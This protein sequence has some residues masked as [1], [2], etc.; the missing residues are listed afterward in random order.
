MKASKSSKNLPSE[1]AF[2]ISRTNVSAAA[3]AAAFLFFI[4]ARAQEVTEIYFNAITSSTESTYL[5]EPSNWYLDSSGTEPF[6]GSLEGANRGMYD[7]YVSLLKGQSAVLTSLRDGSVTDLRNFNYS[8]SEINGNRDILSL[9][10]SKSLGTYGDWNLSLKLESAADRKEHIVGVKMWDFAKVDIRGDWNISV[11]KNG[12]SGWMGLRIHDGYSDKV[13]NFRV[14]GNVVVSSEDDRWLVFYSDNSSFTV[15]GAVDLNGNS[16]S[17]AGNSTV[18]RSIGGLGDADGNG[19]GYGKLYILNQSVDSEVSFNL[20]NSKSYD[21]SGSFQAVAGNGKKALLNITMMASDA[22]NGRQI[23]RFSETGTSWPANTAVENANINDVTV[24]SGRLDIGMYSGMKGNNLSIEGYSG[25]ASDAVF[26]AAGLN[27][28]ENIG[29]VQFDS[30]SFYDGTIV[31]DLAETDCDFMQING[32]VT[33]LSESAKIVFD[34]NIAKD[35]LQIYL[36]ALG[37]ETMEWD[38]MSFKTSESDFDLADIILKTQ[39]GIDGKLNFLADSSSGLTTLQ[40]SLAVVPEPAAMAAI[41]GA[42]ALG[43]AL[44]RRR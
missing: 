42:L 2:G 1:S 20:T 36:D 14:R 18:T 7:A 30:M 26:S 19:K 39:A 16:W 24:S 5:N 44:R 33:K 27:S 13:G 15:D 22:K 12:S 38:L 43:F 11:D 31:F 40:L 37:A 41:L 23:L 28:G 10:G 34:I 3:L 9:G 32:G 35:D 17:I 4:P 21:F 29:R 25:K 8:V 6:E